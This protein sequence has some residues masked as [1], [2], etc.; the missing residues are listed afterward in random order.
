MMLDITTTLACNLGG[1]VASPH[2]GSGGP[3]SISYIVPACLSSVPV[4]IN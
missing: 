1:P 4:E 2:S 3:A